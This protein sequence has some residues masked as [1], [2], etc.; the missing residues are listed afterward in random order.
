MNI[1]YLPTTVRK[2][3]RRLSV[4][5]ALE[6]WLRREER[7]IARWLERREAIGQVGWRQAAGS[8]SDPGQR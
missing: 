5:D 1:E 3:R 7:E 6:R 2:R 8:R 4:S